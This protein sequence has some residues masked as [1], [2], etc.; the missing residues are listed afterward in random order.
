MV[1][2]DDDSVTLWHIND[3]DGD[4]N[5]LFDY[6]VE[7]VIRAAM[8]SDILREEVFVWTSTDLY[9]LVSILCYTLR[10]QY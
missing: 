6:S 8:S 9:I 1:S 10:S 4:C 7:D 5:R 3:E 2:W